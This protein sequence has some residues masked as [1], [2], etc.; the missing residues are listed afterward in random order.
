MFNNGC[1]RFNEHL[2]D[3]IEA[4]LLAG[5]VKGSKA[6]F[7]NMDISTIVKLICIRKDD[8]DILDDLF[9]GL[10]KGRLVELALLLSKKLKE[11]NGKY[12]I[13][14]DENYEIED[15]LRELIDY[16]YR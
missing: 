14:L 11:I 15:K 4:Y 6:V 5:D 2:I 13:K 8:I 7:N 1:I 9:K 16:Y 3:E 12:K 10:T